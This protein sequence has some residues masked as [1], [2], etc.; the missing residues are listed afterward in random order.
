VR[1]WW[2]HNGPCRGHGRLSFKLAPGKAAAR[3]R[4]QRGHLL[5]L[6]WASEVAS[7]ISVEGGR[8]AAWRELVAGAL[9][10]AVTET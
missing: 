8:F 10:P 7:E 6:P 1:G 3:E 4:Q 2:A 9:P 5:T